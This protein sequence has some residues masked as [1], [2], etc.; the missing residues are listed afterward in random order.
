MR[1]RLWIDVLKCE[2]VL[3]FVNL[4]GGNL[5]RNDPAKQAIFHGTSSRKNFR[6][7]ILD[8]K[9]SPAATRTI[10]PDFL[11]ALCGVPLRTLRSKT[12]PFASSASL[13]KIRFSAEISAAPR[14]FPVQKREKL[15]LIRT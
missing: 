8:C 5:T 11:C 6:L 3:V 13:E 4:L 15:F 14:P 2:S 1:R 7:M 10:H 12:L 9:F